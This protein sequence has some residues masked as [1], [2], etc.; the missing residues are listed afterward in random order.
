MQLLS[1]CHNTTD[2]LKIISDIVK[3]TPVKHV[4]DHIR[5]LFYNVDD[6]VEFLYLTVTS[7]G[8]GIL[9]GPGGFG[10]SEITKAFF[11]YFNIPVIVKV[12]HSSMDVEALLGIPNMKKLTNESTYEIAFEKSVFTIPGVLILEEFLDVKPMVA[13]ALKDVLT[14]GG[15]RNGTDFIA[16]KIGTIIICSNKS[17]EEVTVDLS[18]EA[19][20]K[21]RFP[22]STYAC[23][24]SFEAIDYTNLFTTVDKQSTI[25][26]KDYY[27]LLADLCAASC[28]SDILIS[29]R[30]AL[31]A[32]DAL[33]SS[34]NIDHLQYIRSLD[35]SKIELIKQDIL[36]QK[37]YQE[38]HDKL[39]NLNNFITKWTISSSRDY[40]AFITLK[41]NLLH[42]LQI[43]DL[44]GD[45]I[46]KIAADLIKL[47]D[48]KEYEFR[49]IA[50]DLGVQQLEHLSD[51]N[52]LYGEITKFLTA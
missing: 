49:I 45:A 12:G 26:H 41:D 37:Q 17:P 15:H 32:R 20:Y 19:F 34:K 29:P 7:K 42:Q 23:W 28:T 33:L 22:Y 35:F 24:D 10:K 40:V 5:T 46:I 8:N 3:K 48:E 9:H 4:K 36:E 25:D 51:L 30:I 14:E 52:N 47:L 2:T 50:A 16:S 1:D 21:E 18:T 44:V 31:K 43:Y 13:A 38:L 27:N 6:I 11:D 39:I